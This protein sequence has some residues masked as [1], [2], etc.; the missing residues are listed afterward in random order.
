MNYPILVDYFF[1]GIPFM[2]LTVAYRSFP[3]FFA[4]KWYLLVSA[5]NT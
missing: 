3:R 4:L 2:P 5:S 1:L